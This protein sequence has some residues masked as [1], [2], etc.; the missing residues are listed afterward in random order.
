MILFGPAAKAGE[1]KILR[2]CKIQ[3]GMHPVLRQMC[4][5]FCRSEG[6]F[7]GRLI[8]ESLELTAGVISNGTAVNGLTL[9]QCSFQSHRK[10][11]RSGRIGITL[12]RAAFFP[13]CFRSLR[14]YLNPIHPEIRK[15][16]C[17]VNPSLIE[18]FNSDF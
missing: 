15:S 16:V 5:P 13:L 6:I 17:C 2:D 8:K 9:V 4:M 10:R 7:S 3:K 14:N 1:R 12:L 18:Y 11:S